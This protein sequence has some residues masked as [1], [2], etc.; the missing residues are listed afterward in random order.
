MDY[1]GREF[2]ASRLISRL[3]CRIFSLKR[4]ASVAPKSSSRPALL[5]DVVHESA[6]RI[7]SLHD[8]EEFYASLA[9]VQGRWSFRGVA[10]ADWHLETSLHL[11]TRPN[12]DGKRAESLFIRAFKRKA[13]HFVSHLPAD[14]DDLEWLALMQHF[15]VP[16]RLLDFTMSPY[17]AL[18]FAVKELPLDLFRSCFFDSHG[19]HFVAPVQPLRIN[20][21]QSI[22]QGMFLCPSDIDLSFEVNLVQPDPFHEYMQRG[23]ILKGSEAR[24]RVQERLTTV[25]RKAVISAKGAREILQRLASMNITSA[26]LFPGLEGYSRSI[27][28]RYRALQLLPPFE[29]RVVGFEA[30]E[31]FDS[32]G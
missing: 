14:D 8:F 9:P 24:K 31:E 18:Y 1:R 23:P 19:L 7:D 15:G 2:R 32:L 11:A 5:S 28:E 30:L 10:N 13:H 12:K 27:V 20:E 17:V 21:R 22:Q 29:K 4:H 26:S 6:V 16:T 25:V 3:R